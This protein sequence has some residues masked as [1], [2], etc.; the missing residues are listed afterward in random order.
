M[1]RADDALRA[2]CSLV[3]GGPMKEIRAVIRPARLDALREALRKHPDFPGMTVVRARGAG[4]HPGEAPAPGI[5]GELTEDADRVRVEI[6][7]ADE[8]VE[9]LLAV[10]HAAC[11][12]GQRGDGIVWVVPVE[13][14]R[15]LREG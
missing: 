11:H 3:Q 4:Y 13:H 6:V 5:R 10:I 1:S 7:A 9:A 8:Q 14:F 12:T 2:L 15:R